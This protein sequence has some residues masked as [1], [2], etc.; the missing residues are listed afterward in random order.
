M[1]VTLRITVM[2][3]NEISGM[4]MMKVGGGDS[5]TREPVT[6]FATFYHF[7]VSRRGDWA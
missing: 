6:A 5:T 1:A 7:D 2:S 3:C 4:S